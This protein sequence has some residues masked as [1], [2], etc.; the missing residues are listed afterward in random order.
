MSR[1]F[2]NTSTLDKVVKYSTAAGNCTYLDD[3]LTPRPIAFTPEK[4]SILLPNIDIG[5]I[6][7]TVTEKEGQYVLSNEQWPSL[8]SS[9]SS[10]SEAIASCFELVQAAIKEYIFESE[11]NLSGDGIEFRRFLLGRIFM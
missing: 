2:A 10:L 5:K 7:F 4:R 8:T 1:G 11:A 6:P 3:S 9:G